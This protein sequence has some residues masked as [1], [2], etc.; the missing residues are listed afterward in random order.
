[1]SINTIYK[2]DQCEWIDCESPD[3]EDFKFLR[4]KYNIN[5]LLL[6][7]TIDSN[8]LPKFEKEGNVNF[9]LVRENIKPQ[10]QNLNTTSD[11]STKLGILVIDKT[12][13]TIH[14]VKNRSVYEY[15]D[16]VKSAQN[17][18]SDLIA[19]GLAIKVF[20]SYDI[21]SANLMKKSDFIETEIFLNNN[22]DTKQ[23][24]RLYKLKRKAELN[25]RIINMS[26]EWVNNFKQL[27]ITDAQFID[28]KDKHKDI[29]TDFEHLST[30]INNMISMSIAL[31]DQ[32]A[33]Q[34]MKLLA[35]YSVYFLPI[36][37][38]AGVYGM[39]FEVM[40]ELHTQYGYY[41]TLAVMALIVIIT[42][43]YFRTKKW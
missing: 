33:N 11:I 23:I 40:P 22:T 3:K 8:H 1:M 37:F 32:K 20:K 7:D 16:Y 4:K 41:L 9:F 39:N 12:I 34:V 6:E 19:L 5:P 28:L 26:S 35:I 10:H 21:E 14:R 24:K 17:I 30:Q 43:I 25:L 36:T 13:I 38:I 29:I 31:S 18:T 27:N 15:K 42:F 2:S